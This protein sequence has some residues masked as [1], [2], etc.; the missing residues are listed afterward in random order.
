MFAVPPG[1]RDALEEAAARL[2]WRPLLLGRVEAGQ[3]LFVGS[4]AVDGARVRNLLEVG[5]DPQ[6][7][8]RALVGMAP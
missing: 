2:C 1:R 3:G 5:G 7:Y 6:A 8:A 4:R